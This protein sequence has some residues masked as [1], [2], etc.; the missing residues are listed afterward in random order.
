MAEFPENYPPMVEVKNVT[1]RFDLAEAVKDVSFHVDK[2]DIF[3]LVGSD[4]AGK[5]TLL[6][7]VATMIKPAQGEIFVGGLNVAAQRQKIKNIIGYMPQ[8]F[9]LYQDLTVE[10]NMQFF[11]DVFD[12]P[13]KERKTRKEKYLGFSNLLPFTDRL[14]GNL[15]GGMKQKLGLACVLVHEPQLLILD[16]PTNGVD[17]VSRHE[18]WEILGSMKKEGMTIIV[19]T[20]YLDEG[21]RCDNLGLMHSSILMDTATP[22]DIRGGFQ[23]LEEAIIER[24]KEVDGDLA[25]DTFQL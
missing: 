21:E 20:A 2:G 3:G 24:I 1:F 12:I 14:A 17:P 8:R 15:S 11:M 7:L 13:R 16:E 10:E 25:H 5:S 18:F 9:G 6:R 4:G 22:A 23:T 19:S